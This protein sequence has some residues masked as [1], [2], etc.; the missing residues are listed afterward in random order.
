MRRLSH[1][2]EAAGEGRGQ[3]LV[4]FAG[5]LFGIIALVALVI[6]GG[7][8]F[9]QQRVAQNGADAAANAGTVVIA[10]GLSG[11]PRTGYQVYAAIESSATSN[12]L[13]TWSGTYTDGYGQSLGV[14]VTNGGTIPATARG[15]AVGGHRTS[16]TTFGRV[17]GINQLVATADATV[18][19]G[20]VNP[21]CAA[22]Q[23]GCTLLPVTFPV[24]VFQC[25]STGNVVPG[26]WIGAPPPDHGGDPY[27]PIVGLESLPSASNPTGDTSKMAILPLCKSSGTS[28][29][30]FGW[31]D[32]QPG[33]NLAEEITGPLTQTV[34]IPDWFQAQ[35]GNPNSVEDELKA[36]IHKFVLIPLHNG[37]CRED[38]GATSV[39]PADMA[40]KDPTGNN[41]WYYVHTLAVF[42]PDQILVQGSNVNDCT[43]APGSPI[44]PSTAGGFLGCLKGWFV[45]YVLSGPIIPGGDIDPGTPI[46]IQLLK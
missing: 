33:M 32:L 25:D 21:S 43:K 11:L 41:T 13:E 20:P 24:E 14:A 6:D 12:R 35:T 29:G 1:T 3:I 27:W 19:A 28:S 17:I 42:Y 18:V 34:T 4:L 38:P 36:Y 10:Q 7:A 45:N 37:A 15:V 5:G 22:A 39:C 44:P 30:T 40:G 2:R 31:L 26:P 8:V 9:A 16:G 46:G 23:D